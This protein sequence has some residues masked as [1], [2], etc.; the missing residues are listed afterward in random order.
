MMIVTSSDEPQ[1]PPVS[2]SSLPRDHTPALPVHSRDD[3]DVGWS[4]RP[5]PDDDERLY[6]ERPPHWESA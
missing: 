5:E 6:R 3:T 4:E 1:D 2:A